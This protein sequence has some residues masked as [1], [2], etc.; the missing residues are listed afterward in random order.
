[1][2]PTLSVVIPTFQ[3]RAALARLLGALEAQTLDAKDYEVVVAVDGSTDGT[4]EMLADRPTPYTLRWVHQ[5]NR[6]RA[7]ACNR[8]IA[9]AL[10][11]VVLILDDDMQP[12]PGCLA[13]HVQAHAAR[14]RLGVLGAVPIVA[15]ADAP[16]VVRHIAAKF[17]AHLDKL[18]RP[19]QPVTFRDFY[20]GHFSI[21]R[22]LLDAV[23]GFDEAFREYGN[24]DGE[25]AVRLLAAGVRLR[26]EPR[27]VAIQ[28]Y[29]KSFA[30][31]ARDT[32]A[33]GRTA[34]LCA[35]KHPDTLRYLKIGSDGA[36]ALKRRAVR[37]VLLA[38]TRVA[39]PVQGAVIRLVAL[40]ERAS[41]A[42][43]DTCYSIAL[44]YFYWLGA[45]SRGQAP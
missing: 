40:A 16:R 19:G 24:E 26:Y 4:V 9:A 34:V 37:R 10:G 12:E 13:V 43:V 41:P 22:A 39:P 17:N 31:L 33:K 30:A 25:L 2:T 18:A 29:D 32:F 23:G 45:R 7:A 11:E 27:A 38:L 42:R 35:Q 20:S 44:D 15:R 1:V 8:G 14:E 6:G 36:T 5:A 28:H 21:R 3:R